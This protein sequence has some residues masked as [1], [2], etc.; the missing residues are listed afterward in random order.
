MMRK[1]ETLLIL[2]IGLVALLANP[3]WAITRTHT[4]RVSDT[5]HQ[6]NPIN[7]H[8]Y[9]PGWLWA[10]DDSHVVIEDTGDGTP[11]LLKYQ[12]HNTMEI[13]FDTAAITGVP[14]TK[15]HIIVD[16][17]LEAGTQVGT[18]SF[19]SGSMDF[20]PVTGVRW[21]PGS[22]G[23][24]CES[25]GT[26]DLIPPLAPSGCPTASGLIEGD[27]GPGP[28]TPTTSQDLGPFVFTNNATTITTSLCPNPD[29]DRTDCLYS[30]ITQ[31][32]TAWGRHE[33]TTGS[34]IGTLPTLHPVAVGGLGGVLTL[35][36][37]YM[38]RRRKS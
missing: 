15:A 5:Y 25:V 33:V 17:I 9:T 28:G 19:D 27:W 26:P 35:F 11:T 12:L 4:Y 36:G 2:T 1:R 14:G 18:G 10:A 34:K 29:P 31:E 13:T 3:A 23:I 16:Q 7:L 24:F 30:Y 22:P 37:A 38:L 6:Y 20:D 21:N 32:G 8:T